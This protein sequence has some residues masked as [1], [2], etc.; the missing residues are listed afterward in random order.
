M[1]KLT[2]RNFKKKFNNW[3]KENPEAMKENKK[4]LEEIGRILDEDIPDPE[5]FYEFIELS[6]SN[7]KTKQIVITAPNNIIKLLD[8]FLLDNGIVALKEHNSLRIDYL[9]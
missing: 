5:L 1:S 4:I 8:K 6:P 7:H 9:R 3:I 2:S